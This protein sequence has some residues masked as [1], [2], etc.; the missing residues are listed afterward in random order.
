MLFTV[1]LRF[2][3]KMILTLNNPNNHSEITAIV[4][5]TKMEGYNVNIGFLN[6]QIQSQ[7]DCGLIGIYSL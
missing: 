1:T 6:P 7:T 3:R 2:I 4:I 5:I